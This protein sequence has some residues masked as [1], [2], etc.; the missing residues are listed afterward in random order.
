MTSEPQQP[1]TT[2][3]PVPR[4]RSRLPLLVGLALAT[5]VLCQAFALPGTVVLV[6]G[7][8][9]SVLAIAELLRD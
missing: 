5:Y 6:A 7:V 3:A 2:R 4:R 1:N 8:V 9:Y